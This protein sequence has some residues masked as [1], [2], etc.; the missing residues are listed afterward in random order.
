MPPRVAWR[1]RVERFGS[2]DVLVNNAATN[3]YYGPLMEIDRPR[4]EKTVQVNLEAALVW[5]QCA[6]K[7]SMARA[8]GSVINLS[9]IGGLSVEH[10]IGWYNVTKAARRAPHAP[11]GGRAR[12]R[13]ARQRV[14]AGPGAHRFR[15]GPVGAVG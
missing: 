3:P 14:G 5:T 8:G 6:W 1:P 13:R 11:A 10:G 9:S 7:A 12:P 2:L 15:P 4:A